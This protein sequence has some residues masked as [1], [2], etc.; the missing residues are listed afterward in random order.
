MNDIK[1]RGIQGVAKTTSTVSRTNYDMGT[2]EEPVRDT[3]ETVEVPIFKTEPAYVKVSASVTKQPRPY[4]SV[5][6]Q[7][8]ISLPCNPVGS[9]IEHAYDIASSWVNEKIQEELEYAFGREDVALNST[10]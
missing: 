3:E 10:A 7:V 2:L 5:R 1:K 8:D 4:E 9:E 6:V